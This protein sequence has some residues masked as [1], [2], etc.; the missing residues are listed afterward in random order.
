MKR[1][2]SWRETDYER[3][4]RAILYLDRHRSE[5]PA[6]EEVAAEAGLS[7]FHFQRLF[8]RWA[9]T[10]PK[11]F[12][13]ALTVDHAKRLLR[14]STSVLDATFEVG[15][16]GPSRLHD[17]FVSLEAVT[18]GEFKSRGAGLR[19]L[20]GVHPSPFGPMLLAATERGIC[21][22]SFVGG[23]DVAAEVE[24]LVRDWRGASLTEDGKAT[25]ALAERIFEGGGRLP[26]LVRGTNFQVQVW[27][28]LLSVPAGSLVTYGELARAVGRPRAPRAAAGAVAANRIA[29]VIPCH[30][31][32]RS[33][34]EPG[35]YRW[36]PT[37]KRA[38]IAR[39]SAGPAR[40]AVA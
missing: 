12:L 14:Q 3:V 13:Q 28:A 38:M 19:I 11:R 18:P 29:Y 36:G 32:I 6:L 15:L 27:R 22:L 7:P 37:R 33:L 10:T 40:A 20:H 25:R 9:G 4:E 16:S 39:E 17:H 24:A 34:G 30:R 1:N 35:G 21:S 5:Q 8:R 2:G 31:V 23:R 26:L